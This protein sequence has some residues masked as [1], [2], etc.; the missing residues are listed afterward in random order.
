MPCI[1]H[2]DTSTDVCS[3]ALADNGVVMEEKV[4]CEGHS[5]ASSLGLY[6]TDCLDCAK[7]NGLSLDA[8]AVSAGPGSYTGLR[9]GVSMAK[10]IC[11]G[12]DIP[13]ISVPTLE[14]LASAVIRN[15]PREDA[16]FCAML[17]ARRMEVYA[18]IYNRDREQVREAKAE[19]VTAGTYASYLNDGRVCF[20]GNGSDK[21]KPV[22]DHPNAVFVPDVH[23]MAAQMVPLAEE[24]YA[25]GLFED[26]A[27]FE[28]FYL[29]EF[30]AVIAKNKVLGEVL[31]P[32]T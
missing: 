6:V 15:H 8:V 2:I 17:D 1:L 29:K 24:R 13:L 21:C 27:Y 9:I 20:F 28:P 4:S 3:A 11:F 5:H 30:L 7:R 32:H 14:L 31:H 22:I 25:K 18:A 10:G 19:I 16:L 23:P 26:V 12:L